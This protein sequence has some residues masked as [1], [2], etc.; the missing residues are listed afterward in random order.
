MVTAALACYAQ[1]M[2]KLASRPYRSEDFAACLS[3]F[4]GNVPAVFSPNERVEFTQAPAGRHEIVVSAPHCLLC[5]L[6]FDTNALK[7]VARP[8][9]PS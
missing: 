5:G 4:D 1:P 7:P 3:L 2:D 9:K 6:T 8:H